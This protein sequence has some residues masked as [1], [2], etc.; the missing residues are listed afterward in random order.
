MK[1]PLKSFQGLVLDQLDHRMDFQLFFPG[2]TIFHY[3]SFHFQKLLSNFTCIRLCI[4]RRDFSVQALSTLKVLP[5]I[6]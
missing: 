4:S 3:F 2:I 1:Q 6:S 5:A